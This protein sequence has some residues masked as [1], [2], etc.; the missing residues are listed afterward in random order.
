MIELVVEESEPVF[1]RPPNDEEVERMMERNATRGM[2][3]CIGSFDCSHWQWAACPK[4]LS[5][6]YQNRKK[7]RSIFIETVCNEYLYI[8]HFFIGAL[9]S[10]NDLNVLHIS[11]V[12]SD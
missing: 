2:L 4:E 1:L 8:R 11:P 10:P 6:K 7:R 3:G 9:D 5:G 12:Y